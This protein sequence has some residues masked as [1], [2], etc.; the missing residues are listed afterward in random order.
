MMKTIFLMYSTRLDQEFIQKISPESKRWLARAVVNMINIDNKIDS[1]ELC[2]MYDAI[3][4]IDE[5]ERAELLEYAKER[6]QLELPNRKKKNKPPP[7]IN[8]NIIDNIL[9]FQCENYPFP[10]N[11]NQIEC[12]FHQKIFSTKGSKN[13]VLPTKD[14]QYL[15]KMGNFSVTDLELL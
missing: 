8:K 7:L 5:E 3:A 6:K 12:K 9:N 15:E 11:F 10:D 13:N 14:F 4:L 2:Y 1:K